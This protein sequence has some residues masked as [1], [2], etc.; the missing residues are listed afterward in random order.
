MAEVSDKEPSLLFIWGLGA[1]AAVICFIGACFQK[2]LVPVF[3]A[4]PL[5][6]FVS[7]YVEIH[8]TDI[9]SYLYTEQGI[10]Y[11]VQSYLSFTLFLSGIFLGLILN[12]QRKTFSTDKQGE[13]S[14]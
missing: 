5:F 7:F 2:W 6:W 13:T 9:G 12:R 11:Y 8:S 1:T 4:F 10:Y 3:A 14:S